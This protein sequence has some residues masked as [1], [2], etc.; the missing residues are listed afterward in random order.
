MP[1][2]DVVAPV[3]VYNLRK[4]FGGQAVLNGIDLHI[5]Q[6]ETVSVL[7]RS[8]TG[9]SVLLKLIVG[10]HKPD[11]GSIRIHG[12][13]ITNLSLEELNKSR[14]GIGFLF[15][16][17]ALYDSLTL[18]ENVA[19]PMRSHIGI[20]EIERKDRARKLLASVGMENDGNKLPSQISGGMKK[21]VGLA[22][23]LALDPDIL[24]FD[25][26]TSGLDPI[27]SSEI[28]E[29]I[30]KLQ[31]ERKTASLVVTH[32]LRGAKTVSDRLVLLNEGHIVIDG[33]F[34]D[35]RES[36]DPFVAKFMRDG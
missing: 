26:P 23:A 19:F 3:A 18:E 35:L 9:K 32:D 17:A 16:D 6:G 21:R 4:G 7:G 1:D 25:E 22:R 15:Q 11:Q 36:R 8:G 20:P 34:N 13:E 14:A 27:T 29:L 12:N 33:T 24:L 28:E 2:Q 30:L 10:L 5:G 31:E